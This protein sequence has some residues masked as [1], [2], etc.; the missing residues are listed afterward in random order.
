ME[1]R[2]LSGASCSDGGG[3]PRAVSHSWGGRAEQSWALLQWGVGV[4]GL[5]TQGCQPQLGGHF[6]AEQS[7]RLSCP[8]LSWALLQWGV[9][10]WGLSSPWEL[11]VVRQNTISDSPSRAQELPVLCWIFLPQQS[12]PCASVSLRRLLMAV[13]CREGQQ[14]GSRRGAAAP[15]GRL[16]CLGL[17]SVE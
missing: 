12:S 16:K 13:Q 15:W 17:L 10:V 3:T 6:P 8:W 7:C 11:G 4:W 1:G 5:S 2:A 14:W 9:G